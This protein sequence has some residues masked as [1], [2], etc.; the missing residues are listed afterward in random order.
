M[1]ETVNSEPPEDLAREYLRVSKDRSGRARSVNEQHTD[2][3]RAATE[4]RLTLGEP[5]L[6]NDVS[7]SRYATKVRKDFGRLLA[8][9]ETGAFCARV[10]ILWESSRGS[11]KVS[12]WVHLVEACEAAGVDIYVTTH[13]RRYDPANARD[14]R[15][16]LEDAVDSEYESSKLSIRSKR[17]VREGAAAGMPHGRMPLG[18]RRRYDPMT[19][20]LVAQEPDPATAPLIRELFARLAAGHS[21]RSIARE[22]Q[23]RGVV[24]GKGLPYS[25]AHL[26]ELA[27]KHAYAGLRVYVP[28]SGPGNNAGQRGPEAQVTEATW[29]PL[30]SRE[31]FWQV[32]AILSDPKRKTTRP[33]RANHLLSMI[34]RCDVCSGPLVA[35]R[36]ASLTYSIYRCH[37]GGHVHIREADL[38]DLAE[39]VMIAYLAREDLSTEWVAAVAGQDD[40]ELQEIRDDLAGLRRRQDEIEEAMADPDAASVVALAQA[41]AKIRAEVSVLEERQR[42]RLT[43]PALAGLIKPGPGIERRWKDAPLEVKRQVARALLS[44][45]LLGELRVTRSPKGPNVVD[46]TERVK[47]KRPKE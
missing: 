22:W 46:V 14:R 5:Y 16:L 38:D 33:G 36:P 43:P 11:R 35:L 42:E 7:A 44:A 28:G 8:D 24:N 17:S 9:L 27:R 21:L 40:D 12:E 25:A 45:E 31:Q 18:Y 23:A 3:E 37:K 34:A 19:R 30:V 26:R 6:D 10:L 1:T 29:E 47:W 39:R 15:S 20:R 4:H 2:N 13:G 41:A 32:Q